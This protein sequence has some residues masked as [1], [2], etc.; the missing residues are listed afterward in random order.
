[1]PFPELHDKIDLFLSLFWL[2]FGRPPICAG[3]IFGPRPQPKLY[4][5]STNDERWLLFTFD[6]LDYPSG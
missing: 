4:R 6:W 2:G 5:C 3:S 1:M